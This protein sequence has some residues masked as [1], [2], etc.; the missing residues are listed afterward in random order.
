MAVMSDENCPV[1]IVSKKARDI[2]PTVSGISRDREIGIRVSRRVTGQADTGIA[3]L[4]VN[5]N[6]NWTIFD[7]GVWSQ[8]IKRT[9]GAETNSAISMG[10][11]IVWVGVEFL[12]HVFPFRGCGLV[13]THDGSYQTNPP[14][15]Y[16]LD[17][18]RRCLNPLH[19]GNRGNNRRNS[20]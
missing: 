8:T 11:C 7:F 19:S 5:H 17:S 9:P 6:E 16:M 15:G 10:Q 2:F 18:F 12:S 13:F 1:A 20:R 4:A 14:E 3:F